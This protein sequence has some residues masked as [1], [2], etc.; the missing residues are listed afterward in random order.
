MIQV[1]VNRGENTPAYED[2]SVFLP[3]PEQFLLDS[4]TIQIEVPKHTAKEFLD[5]YESFN[6]EVELAFTPWIPSLKAILLQEG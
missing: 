5:S 2:L 6:P 1:N 3:Y 4:L